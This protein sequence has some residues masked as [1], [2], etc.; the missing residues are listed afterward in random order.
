MCTRGVQRAGSI[1]FQSLLKEIA[2]IIAPCS[3]LV[4]DDKFSCIHTTRSDCVAPSKW[5][6]ITSRNH[7]EYCG[8]DNRKQEYHG[9]QFVIWYH[10]LQWYRILRH[11]RCILMN[12][13][14]SILTN[15]FCDS[16]NVDTADS[17]T[18]LLLMGE[19]WRGRHGHYSWLEFLF[20]F[21]RRQSNS[22]MYH[23][24]VIPESF[25]MT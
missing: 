24:L 22:L 9:S 17:F 8:S 10:I 14:P 15:I 18:G 20:L 7:I 16:V 6:N 19:C 12:I 13:V 2:K 1:W 4:Q 25:I 11:T 23:N 3:L 5:S 21:V